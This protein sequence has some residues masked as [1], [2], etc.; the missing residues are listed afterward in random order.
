VHRL[1]HRLV[2]AERER[3]VADAAAEIARRA[4]SA[5]IQ[6]VASMKSTRVVVVL[7]DAGRD[8]EDVRIEDDVLGRKPTCSTSSS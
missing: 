6:R 3:Q 1:A 5:L 8:R 2:A 4:G 7:L